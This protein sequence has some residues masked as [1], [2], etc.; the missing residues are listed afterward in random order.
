MVQTLIF[1]REARIIGLKLL[2]MISEEFI[3]TKTDLST[4]RRAELKSHFLQHTTVII[5]SMRQILE[6]AY[7]TP[8]RFPLS[9]H[10]F[11]SYDSL[12]DLRPNLHM[13]ALSAGGSS[14]QLCQSPRGTFDSETIEICRHALE[15]LIQLFSWIPLVQNVTLPVVNTILKYVQLNDAATVDLGKAAMSCVNEILARNCM[16]QEFQEYLF[17][18]FR[19]VFE[20]LKYLSNDE[21]SG[22]IDD[23]DDE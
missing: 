20:V 11:A 15:I 23:L 14:F 6:D 16:P 2:K 9:A 7:E 17:L 18:I 4:A 8:S 19:N 22:I 10:T 3:S 13:N 5:E 12:A 21:E 1:D